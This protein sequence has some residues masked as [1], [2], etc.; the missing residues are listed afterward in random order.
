MT[1]TTSI[2]ASKPAATSTT[3]QGAVLQFVVSVT[4]LVALFFPKNAQAVNDAST[5]IQGYL[6]VVVSVGVAAAPLVMT[7]LGRFKAVQALH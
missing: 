5:A 4:A 6:P 7:I 1:D 3:I 2:T